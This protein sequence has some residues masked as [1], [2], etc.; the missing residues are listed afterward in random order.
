[1]SIQAPPP[2]PPR[3]AG[4]SLRTIKKVEAKSAPPPIKQLR[5]E[6]EYPMNE[7]SWILLIALVGYAFVLPLLILF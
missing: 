7:I 1:M 6:I 4:E 2:P 3:R 5:I